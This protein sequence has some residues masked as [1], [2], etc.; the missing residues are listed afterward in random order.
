MWKQKYKEVIFVG[1]KIAVCIHYKL[2]TTK[3]KTQLPLLKSQQK[4][5]GVGSKNR[6]LHMVPAHN[7]TTAVGR[8]PKPSLQPDLWTHLYPHL[9]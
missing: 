1:L 6:V 8:P 5:Q 9:M 4:K 2:W 3:Y 7:I